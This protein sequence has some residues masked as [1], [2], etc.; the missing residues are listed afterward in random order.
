[1]NKEQ[2]KTAVE[3]LQCIRSK[4]LERKMTISQL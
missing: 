3:A 1:M 2:T 4:L